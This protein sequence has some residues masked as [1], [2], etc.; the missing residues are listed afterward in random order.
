MTSKNYIDSLKM[1]LAS[2][3]LAVKNKTV[4]EIAGELGYTDP[5]YFSR[6]FK[7][8]TGFSSKV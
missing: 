5:Y 3:M 8:L 1:Q 7:E 4:K 2:E 6:R